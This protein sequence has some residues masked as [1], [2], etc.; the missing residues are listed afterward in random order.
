ML[1]LTREISFTRRSR[2]TNQWRNFSIE[3]ERGKKVAVDGEDKRRLRNRR[4]GFSFFLIKFGYI[5]KVCVYMKKGET[6]WVW[7]R[8]VKGGG[9]IRAFQK[10]PLFYLGFIKNQ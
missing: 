9:G 1:T 5:R 4:F 7:G 2:R 8:G 10:K 6:R 3:R